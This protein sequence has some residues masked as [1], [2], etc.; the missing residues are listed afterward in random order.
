MSS[1]RR[2]RESSDDVL[3]LREEY[4]FTKRK[5]NLVEGIMDSLFIGMRDW[6]LVMQPDFKL[7][8]ANEAFLE[9]V[10]M[11]KEDVIGKH[12]YEAAYGLTAHCRGAGFD[13]PAGKLPGDWKFVQCV[14][15]EEYGRPDIR[16]L[17]EKTA[18]SMEIEQ[19]GGLN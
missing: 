18:I 11:S 3:Q 14:I 2:Y 15:L 1:K 10:R 6:V 8:D 9:A 12:C 16:T 17:G 19:A 7:I 5:I 4:Q 13:C